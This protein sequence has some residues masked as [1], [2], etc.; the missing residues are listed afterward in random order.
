MTIITLNDELTIEDDTKNAY[1]K[2]SWLTRYI[3]FDK[4]IDKCKSPLELVTDE[5]IFNMNNH[6]LFGL[7]SHAYTYHK[8]VTINPTDIWILLLSQFKTIVKE[9]PEYY[10]SLFTESDTKTE[11]CVLTDS[12]YELPVNA[13]KDALDEHI[14]FN[15]DLL[16]PKFTT[17]TTVSNELKTHL[18]L[19]MS[20]P[21]FSYS[22][23][24]CGIRNIKIG[25]TTN[26]WNNLCNSFIALN[27]I[28]YNESSDDYLLWQNAV[29]HIIDILYESSKGDY[30]IEFFK[31][32]FTKRN[33]GSGGDI[34]INGWITNFYYKLPKVKKIC[35]FNSHVSQIDYKNKSTGKNYIMISGGF[36]YKDVDSFYELEYSKHI[37]EIVQ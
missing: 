28:F 34:E 24:L 33:I 8:N 9:N 20:S 15:T 37:F 11:L 16:F 17:D 7:I 29:L 3:T 25:G 30:D 18:L 10:R 13:I 27:K 14:K 23:M 21:Y 19:D 2:N 22:M 1:S 26:D 36:N 31:D 32:I 4:N 12:L 6:G 35:N 5:Q